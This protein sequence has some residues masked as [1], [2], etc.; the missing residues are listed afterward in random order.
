MF[1]FSCAKGQDVRC[2]GLVVEVIHALVNELEPLARPHH[3]VVVPLSGLV[4]RSTD[5]IDP[6]TLRIPPHP[7]ADG[8]AEDC[9]YDDA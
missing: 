9:G 5:T 4:H 2:T 6:F 7:V 1:C 3:M 8:D